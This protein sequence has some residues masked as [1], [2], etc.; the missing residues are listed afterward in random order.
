[1]LHYSVLTF[2]L[3][4]GRVGCRA[5]AGLF[6]YSKQV[7]RPA[8]IRSKQADIKA[9]PRLINAR[10]PEHV[11]SQALSNSYTHVNHYRSFQTL[12]LFALAA[13]S[14]SMGSDSALLFL[15]FSS[16]SF[17]FPT[18]LSIPFRYTTKFPLPSILVPA[19]RVTSIICSLTTSPS[20][21]PSSL[22]VDEDD[23]D[24]EGDGGITSLTVR[25]TSFARFSCVLC[26]EGRS[27]RLLLPWIV[28]VA[29]MWIWIGG[30]GGWGM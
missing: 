21:I 20:S 27:R 12:N 18:P 8:A 23:E 16:S 22:L 26:G 13:L 17:P 19:S 28:V 4:E 24:E 15:P 5:V 7:S 30:E 6:R 14:T 1:M 10:S 25:V 9:C 2:C 29:F 3:I 11:P